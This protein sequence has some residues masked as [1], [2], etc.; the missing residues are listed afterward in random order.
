MKYVI[1]TIFIVALF[2]GFFALKQ[3]QFNACRA[4]GFSSGYCMALIGR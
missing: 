3:Y 4:D 2:G 1:G